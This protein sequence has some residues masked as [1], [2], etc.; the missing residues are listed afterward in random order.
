MF[1]DKKRKAFEKEKSFWEPALYTPE[2]KVEVVEVKAEKV[3]EPKAPF[4]EYKIRVNHPCLCVRKG[5]ST[6]YEQVGL[7]VDRGIYKVLDEEN[8]FGK[9]GEDQWIMLSYTTKA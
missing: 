7:I 1:M 5:P 3:E 6:D 9:I 4:S 8:G 2:T